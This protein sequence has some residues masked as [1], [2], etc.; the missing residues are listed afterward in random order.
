MNA[1]FYYENILE[2]IIILKQ[3][4]HEYAENNY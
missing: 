1:T 4:I 3:T 2:Y